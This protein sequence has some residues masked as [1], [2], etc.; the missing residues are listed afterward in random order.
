MSCLISLSTESLLILQGLPHLASLNATSS[1]KLFFGTHPHPHLHSTSNSA[2][3]LQDLCKTS[4][5]RY[6]VCCSHASQILLCMQ[7]TQDLGKKQILTQGV[8]S[9]ASE[10]AFLADFQAAV[11]D[12]CRSDRDRVPRL[13]AC[14]SIFLLLWRAASGLGIC[15]RQGLEGQ[16]GKWGANGRSTHHVPGSELS[17]LHTYLVQ[18]ALK[19]KLLLE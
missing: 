2:I 6:H 14:R 8:W 3:P 16:R 17:N 18:R 7:I 10:F 1:Q 15:W 9:G 11:H 19:R 4:S 12:P 5:H 13:R